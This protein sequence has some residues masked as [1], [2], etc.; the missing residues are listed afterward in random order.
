MSNP[1]K[2]MMKAGTYYVGDLC[3]VLRDDWEEVCNAVIKYPDVLEGIFTLPNGKTFA[4]LNTMHGDGGYLD[5]LGNDYSVDSGGI[6]CISVEYLTNEQLD[7]IAHLGHT[8]HFAEDFEVKND[9]GRLIF[10]SVVIDTNDDED[11]VEDED[12]CYTR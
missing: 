12:G 1:S 10:G 6:G 7:G 4:T 3:Y 9:S 2:L 5:N 8:R 11:V